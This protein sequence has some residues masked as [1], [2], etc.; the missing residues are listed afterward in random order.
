M[1]VVV[2]QPRLTDSSR[3]QLV[4]VKVLT[5]THTVD[6]EGIVL[7]KHSQAREGKEESKQVQGEKVGEREKERKYGT[8]TSRNVVQAVARK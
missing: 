2:A 6:E 5:Y 8:S 7:G 4:K 3:L 1:V